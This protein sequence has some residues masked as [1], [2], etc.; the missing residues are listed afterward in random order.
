V[1]ARSFLADMNQVFEDFVAVAL[2][3]TLGVSEYAFPQ[4]LAL[5]GARVGVRRTLALDEA[6]VV[7]LV[8]DLSWW[9]A[10]RCTFAGDVKY[11]RVAAAGVEHPDLYQ[12]L[13]Y[14]TAADL[15]G[16]LLVY[17]AGEGEPVS[18]TVVH[19][20]KELHVVALDLSGSA[21]DVLARVA[22][23]A[24]RV[25]LLRRQARTGSAA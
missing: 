8:P 4:G 13:A 22:T 7:G 16:G 21:A 11:K 6:G 3:E 15:P 23:V 24:Q 12:L 1:P 25:R 10:R 5:G 2:R 17:A 20:G 19:A 9:D 14:V 18:H